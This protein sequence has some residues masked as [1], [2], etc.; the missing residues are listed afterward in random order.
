MGPYPPQNL[1]GWRQSQEWL[2]RCPVPPRGWHSPQYTGPCVIL[3]QPQPVASL[4]LLFLLRTL[5]LNRDSSGRSRCLLEE[6]LLSPYVA[7]TLPFSKEPPLCPCPT[8]PQH[9]SVLPRKSS[10]SWMH[11]LKSQSSVWLPAADTNL[12]RSL[13]L[14]QPQLLE[15]SSS[16]CHYRG[17]SSAAARAGVGDELSLVAALSPQP[18]L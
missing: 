3:P 15:V 10:S 18:L 7:R 8:Q 13:H 1:L 6:F 5:Q 14:V 9:G 11:V 12:G 2:P 17:S 16:S 4:H